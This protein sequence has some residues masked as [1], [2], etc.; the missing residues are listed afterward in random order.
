M[1]EG[2]KKR[3]NAMITIFTVMDSENID[4]SS[5]SLKYQGEM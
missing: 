1:L 4:L 2:A 5:S 3:V